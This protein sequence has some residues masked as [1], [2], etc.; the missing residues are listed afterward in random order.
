[1]P[2]EAKDGI[3]TKKARVAIIAERLPEGILRTAGVVDFIFRPPA[4]E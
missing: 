4:R 3:K 1:V 2:A